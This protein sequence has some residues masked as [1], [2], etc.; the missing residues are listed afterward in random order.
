MK[1]SKAGVRVSERC[2]M[3]EYE[4]EMSPSSQS[5]GQRR[6]IKDGTKEQNFYLLPPAATAEK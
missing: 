4:Y 3:N 6:I 5:V 2:S 1:Q